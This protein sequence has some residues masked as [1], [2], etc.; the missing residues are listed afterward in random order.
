MAREVQ[1]ALIPEEF[2]PARH[3][4]V[5]GSCVP[6]NDLGGD[7]VDQFEL[8][9]GRTAF[10]VADV[11]GKGIAASLLAAALQGA[12][13]A[14]IDEARPLGEVVQRVNRVMCRLAPLGKFISMLVCVLDARGTLSFVN[15]GH[16]PLALVRSTGVEQ[17][18]TKGLA[19][20]IEASIPY[21]TG[22]VDLRSG[23]AFVLY[24][25][26]VLECE[27]PARELFGSDRLD[28]TLAA[29]RNLT[30]TAMLAA[31]LSTVDRFRDG[32]RVSDDSTVLIVRY[33]GS[34][35]TGSGA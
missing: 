9:D 33:V 32:A 25:D 13:A 7:Y 35:R 27:N 11:C 20:G 29:N 2:R 30:A 5:A 19:L 14:E 3:F 28:A 21:A 4:E 16:C 6:C 18:V 23:D 24:S 8:R 17:L 12:L 22:S 10:I 1:S 31:L 15:A 34:G 26:G